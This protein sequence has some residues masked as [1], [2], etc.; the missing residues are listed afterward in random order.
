MFVPV[1][2]TWTKI[3]FLA[4]AMADPDLHELFAVA[5]QESL[6]EDL[7]CTGPLPSPLFLT[8]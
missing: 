3:K 4:R 1:L 6:P 2:G 7:N 8:G 5:E